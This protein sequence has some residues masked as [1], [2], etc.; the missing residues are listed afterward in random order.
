MLYDIDENK[1]LWLTGS[2]DYNEDVSRH[3]D[4]LASFPNQFTRSYVG[5]RAAPQVVP[6]L[7]GVLKPMLPLDVPLTKRFKIPTD[8]KFMSESLPRRSGTEV[9]RENPKLIPKIL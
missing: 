2:Q 9:L 1:A 8:V 4:H 6:N 7:E 5:I 3:V